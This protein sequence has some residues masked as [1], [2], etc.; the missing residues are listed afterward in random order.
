MVVGAKKP[1]TRAILLTILVYF[2]LAETHP[3]ASVQSRVFKDHVIS[4]VQP[5][6]SQFLLAQQSQD[7]V[8][9]I[10]MQS[11]KTKSPYMAIF[12][13]VIPGVVIH[14]SGHIYA[15]KLST[16]LLLFGSE[17]VGVGVIFFG[18]LSGMDSGVPM[19][20]GDN[21]IFIGTALFLCSWIYDIVESPVVVIKQNQKLLQGKNAQ[22]KFQIK[23]RD[24]KFA[25]VWHF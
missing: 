25:I 15:G 11:L 20:G 17:V 4:S 19:G 12:Y 22:L 24:L 21:A 5:E 18:S 23:D 7:S 10:K 9:V 2:P 6:H 8:K 16:G 14:G 1:L 3:A 13:S